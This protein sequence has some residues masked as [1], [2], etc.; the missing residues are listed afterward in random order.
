MAALSGLSKRGCPYSVRDLRCH[1]KRIPGV[2]KLSKE[3]E[4]EGGGKIL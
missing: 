1:G 3:K 2:G 4:L